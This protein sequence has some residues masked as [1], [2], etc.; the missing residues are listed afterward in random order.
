MPA[1]PMTKPTSRK[2]KVCARMMSIIPLRADERREQRP[3]RFL[4]KRRAVITRM[5][6][7]DD[8]RIKR[9]IYR[10][11]DLHG[12]HHREAGKLPPDF[13]QQL[14]VQPAYKGHTHGSHGFL[15]NHVFFPIFR[16]DPSL[17]EQ[18]VAGST[19]DRTGHIKG[20]SF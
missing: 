10:K 11:I 12:K 19:E 6:E 1:N 16:D 17:L 18:F 13:L 3:V 20:L 14:I 5:D 9:K 7:V 2:I 4:R 15:E 8:G